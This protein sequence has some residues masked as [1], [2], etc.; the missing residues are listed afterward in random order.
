MGLLNG[1]GAEDHGGS[2]WWV[3]GCGGMVGLGLSFGS[4]SSGW[5]VCLVFPIV[6]L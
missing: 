5:W 1:F 6:T 3:V 4:G 2:V